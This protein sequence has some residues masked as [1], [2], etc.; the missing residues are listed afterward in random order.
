[1]EWA[2]RTSVARTGAFA[3]TRSSPH[4]DP[5]NRTVR[6]HAAPLRAALLRSPVALAAALL[7]ALLL[8]AP[9]AF[10]QDRALVVESIEARGNS[11]TS[12]ETIHR[13]FPLREGDAIDAASLASALDELRRSDLFESAELTTEPGAERGRVRIVLDVREKGVQLRV[14]TGYT[15]LSGWYLIPAELAFDNRLGHGERLR[16]QAKIGYRVVGVELGFEERRFGDGR[17]SWGA[18]I[19]TQGVARVYFDDG[20]ELE[21]QVGRGGIEA[22]LGRRFAREWGVV[23][24]AGFEAVDAESTATLR[25]D[26]PVTGADKGDEISGDAIPEGV[27]DDLGKRKRTFLHASL[28]HDSRSRRNIASTPASGAWGALRADGVLSDEESFAA[29]TADVRAFH[30]LGDGVLAL[31]L[32]G[33]VV[34]EEAPFYDRFHLGGLYTVRGF[35]S[36]SL[37]DP[38][39]ST[40]FGAA[41]L[42]FRTALV[43]RRDRPRLAGVLFVD[44][45]V[46]DDEPAASAGFGVRLR[47]PWLESLGLDLGIPL[48]DSPIEEAFHAN[49]SLG[50]SF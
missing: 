41:S 21:H 16:L 33:G 7:C 5:G 28:V 20:V 36:Q 4:R 50:W 34:G 23:G 31:R 8:A 40:V 15:D 27:R 45:G 1:M 13:F 24:G 3:L 30:A 44:G 17:N 46:D 39:G 37:T 18:T 26:D 2:I 25:E 38:E 14:G 49:A 29:L 47:V 9:G 48:T 42:E 32:R 6:R 35:P 22:H 12:L 11:R 43:G 19:S 10:A